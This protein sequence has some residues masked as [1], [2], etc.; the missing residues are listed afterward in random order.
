MKRA[1]L[2]ALLVLAAFAGGSARRHEISVAMA[3]SH[4]VYFAD[5]GAA[6]RATPAADEP[7]EVV[8]D[9]FAFGPAEFDV[10]PGTQVVWIN[11]DDEPH[12]VV[13]ADAKPLFQSP[14][15]DTNEKFAF[16]FKQPGRYPYFCSIHPRMRGV[17][18]VR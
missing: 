10:A 1:I 3:A 13:S 16:V 4:A 18:V 6:P 17:I 5:H 7:N 15:L 9:N 2:V 11:R 14:P 12:T 8:I